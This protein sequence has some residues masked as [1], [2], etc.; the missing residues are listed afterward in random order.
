MPKSIKPIR[1]IYKSKERFVSSR[2]LK[3]FNIVPTSKNQT[4]C[5][6]ASRDYKIKC[7]LSGKR[8]FISLS[9]EELSSAL[10]KTLKNAISQ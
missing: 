5:V 8:Y 6:N 9:C 3:S 7:V 4:E 2:N 10:E 1:S